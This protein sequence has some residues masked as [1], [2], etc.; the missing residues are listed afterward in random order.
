MVGPLSPGRTAR[1][2]LAT[3]FISAFASSPI[4]ADGV[5][6]KVRFAKRTSS[7]TISAAVIRG[8]RDR[9]YV[10]ANEGQTMTVNISSEE[11]NAVFQIY[12]EGE[13]RTMPRAGEQDDAI[14]SSNVYRAAPIPPSP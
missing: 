9:Y 11:R 3:L 5:K 8:D 7:A 1:C 14:Q 6:K 2:L 13:Q 12:L 10:G 4:F